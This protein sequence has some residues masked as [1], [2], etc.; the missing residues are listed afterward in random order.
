MRERRLPERLS[1]AEPL[2]SLRGPSCEAEP[3][4]DAATCASRTAADE[5]AG[6]WEALAA[7]ANSDAEDFA[8]ARIDLPVSMGP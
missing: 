4:R 8:A 5:A 3:R 6:L 2:R 7:S 1:P